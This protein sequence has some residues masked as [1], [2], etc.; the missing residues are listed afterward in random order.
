MPPPTLNTNASHLLVVF[1]SDS[2][3]EGF[4]FHAWYQAVAPGHGECVPTCL[5][6]VHFLPLHPL[7]VLSKGWRLRASLTPGA[8]IQGAVP[9]MSSAVT[10]SSACYLTQCVMVL[11][12]VL[13]AVMRPIAV[14]SSRVRARHGGPLFR[15]LIWVQAGLPSSGPAS[16]QGLRQHFLLSHS[17]AQNLFPMG[18]AKTL[19]LQSPPALLD[20][21]TDPSKLM[22]PSTS[23]QGVGGI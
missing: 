18:M 13:T 20:G 16:N 21:G 15:R 23:L 7:P 6:S 4:G 10:S 22:S 9:M 1:V 2:S 12:T 8:H 17:L 3:V 5:L 11:P 14:P 19:A